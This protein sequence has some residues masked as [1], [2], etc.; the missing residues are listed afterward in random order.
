MR[1]SIAVA[2]GDLDAEGLDSLTRE[3]E[4]ELLLLDAAD[5]VSRPEGDTAPAGAKSGTVTTVGALVVTGVFSPVAMKALVGLV[6]EWR[7]RAQA[8]RVELVEGDD[9]LIV[10]GVS[11][12]K[13]NELIDAWLQRRSGDDPQP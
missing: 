13:Q 4:E 12:R 1:I 3:L 8:R 5:T 9:S 11:A 10:E 2:A 7:Q 6:S